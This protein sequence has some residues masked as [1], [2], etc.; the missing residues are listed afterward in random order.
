MRNSIWK[1]ILH[2]FLLQCCSTTLSNA[3]D[4]NPE[5]TT[6]SVKAQDW[7]EHDD[8]HDIFLR[9]LQESYQNSTQELKEFIESLSTAFSKRLDILENN[10]LVQATMHESLEKSSGDVRSQK[11]QVFFQNG[12]PEQPDSLQSSWNQRLDLFEKSMILRSDKFNVD[13]ETFKLEF[14]RR[15]AELDKKMGE[16]NR[17]V[18][19]ALNNVLGTQTLETA[20]SNPSKQ[21]IASNPRP[22]TPEE[23]LSSL[24]SPVKGN[25]FYGKTIEQ[26]AAE[27]PNDMA[28]VVEIV[29]YLD[30]KMTDYRLYIEYGS[31]H[32]RAP[33]TV[34]FKTREVFTFKLGSRA[35]GK[36]LSGTRTTQQI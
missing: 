16:L 21:L 23:C 17:H 12:V 24:S 3:D 25:S 33:T 27:V 36:S 22:R 14:N 6:E 8:A 1:I 2:V 30:V 5:E 4:L 20:P 11:L 32:Q 34:S 9:R 28:L 7:H 15:Y 31:E 26:I 18:D 13:F 29:N 10:C 19:Q 35:P